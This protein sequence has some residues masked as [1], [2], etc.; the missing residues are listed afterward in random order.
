[1]DNIDDMDDLET[2]WDYSDDRDYYDNKYGIITHKEFAAREKDL[3]ERLVGGRVG[4][5]ST[6]RAS[7]IEYI[8]CKNNYSVIH[9]DDGETIT[10][11]KSLLKITELLN[12][13]YLVKCNRGYVINI[14]DI[15]YIS[16]DNKTFKIK[17]DAEIPVSKN[18]FK[19]F[20]KMLS[21][22]KTGV[23]VFSY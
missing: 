20:L 7:G 8:K 12:R 22:S 10:V 21:I 16:D 4:I 5:L 3:F 18:G 17:S 9:M 1:M 19:N 13:S 15:D 2:D 14:N 6:I 23:N 11:S